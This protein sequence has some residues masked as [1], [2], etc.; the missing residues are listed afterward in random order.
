M[1]GFY[2]KKGGIAKLLAKEKRGIFLGQDIF[3][4]G[5]GEENGTGFIVQIASSSSGGWRGLTWQ[6]TPKLV[7]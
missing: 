4:F 2:R 6:I 7:D 3:F 1:G 5:G